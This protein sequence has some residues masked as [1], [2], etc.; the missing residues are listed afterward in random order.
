MRSRS[1]DARRTFLNFTPGPVRNTMRGTR[2][3]R[4]PAAGHRHCPPLFSSMWASWLACAFNSSGLA[5]TTRIEPTSRTCDAP[6]KAFAAVRGL[7]RAAELQHRLAAGH[8][9]IHVREN[10]G[11]EERAVK[12]PRRVV[13]LVA[14]A[15][16]IEAVAL[17]WV[18]LARQRETVDDPAAA[19]DAK[20]AIPRASRVRGRGTPRRTGRCV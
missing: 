17:A 11:I 13:D 16:R 12:L 5:R 7:A 3:S 20:G 1:G 9:Q 8:R 19:L 4:P 18:K 2:F 6:P 14:L 10:L 15:Q